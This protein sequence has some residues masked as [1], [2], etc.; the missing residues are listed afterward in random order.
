MNPG[1]IPPEPP[2]IIRRLLHFFLRHED[3]QEREA[4]FDALFGEE[5]RERGLHR[6]RRVYLIQVLLSLPGLV[7][8]F[9]NWEAAMLKNYLTIA[10]R[11]IVKNKGI[12]FINVA[13]LA[14]GMACSL[15]IFLWVD[16]QMSTDKSQPNKDRIFR[17]EEGDWADLQTSYRKVLDTFPEIEKYVQFSSWEKP[18]LRIGDRL[19]DSRDLVFADDAVFEVF[20]FRFLWGNPES[21]LKDPYSLVLARSES[22]RLFG[23]EDPMGKTIILDN[24][25]PFTVTGVVEDPDDFHL[26]WRAMGPFKSLPAIKG[27]PNFLNERNDNFPTYLLLQ[28]QTDVPEFEKKLAAAI[29]AIRDSP[30]AFRL[31][32]FRDIY[33]ARDMVRENGVKHGNMSLVVLFSAIAVLILL[34]ACV[35]FINLVTAR[36]SSRAKEISVRKAA[37]AIRK[38]L[39]VQFLGETSLTVFVAL[40]LALVLVAAYL[41]SFARLTGEPLNVDWTAGKWLVGILSIFLFTSL[42]SGLGPALFLSSLEPVA[43]MRGKGSRPAGR[44]PFRTVLTIFQFAVATFLIIG[45]LVV[46]GQLEY[47]KTKGLGFDQEQVL[48]VPLKGKLKETP[49]VLRARI[50]AGK[51]VGETKGVFR[52][53][54][55]QSPDIRGVTFINESPGELTNTN[56]WLVRG[57]KKPMIILHTDPDIMDVLGLELVDGRKLSWDL[58]SDMGLSYLV[59]EEAVPFLGLEPLFG[60]T[61]RANFGPSQVVGIIKNFHFRS[62]HQKIGPMAIVWFDGW[63][64][65]AAIKISGTNIARTIAYVREVWGEVNP[66]APF[67]YTFMDETIGRLYAAEARL[68]GILEIFVGLAVFLSC[69]GL[70]GLSAYVVAQKTKEIG[71]RKVL[72]AK[73]SE[74]VVLLSK[75]FSRWVLLA[76]VFAWPAAYYVSGKWLQGFAYRVRLGAAPFLLASVSVLAVALLTVS[77]QS[78]KAATASPAEAI[79]HE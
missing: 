68:G 32:P 31:R 15:L 28:S 60:E 27:R 58:E 3:A 63:T 9:I 38:N 2:P 75:D 36:S 67:S 11:N 61:F 5:A 44:A 19:F 55:L 26:G 47:L 40:V 79:R 33:F 66:Q 59:N 24:T 46:L 62:L 23:S 77:F 6:A 14:L 52:Q 25:F 8:N 71:I 53:R 57:L 65:N 51:T 37:G 41:P 21:A 54:L 64:N 48:L 70:F 18:I 35:N 29:N 56:T 34:I 76:N 43:L 74:I 1:Q 10:W 78:V 45:A 30:A 49:Q 72:G 4:E 13:G 7:T 73:T 20:K 50:Q 42:A 69:L 17:L 16:G 22:Q 12:S 39:L